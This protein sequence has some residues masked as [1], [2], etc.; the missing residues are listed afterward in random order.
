MGRL[1]SQ[2]NQIETEI[3]LITGNRQD[4]DNAIA[5]KN[6]EITDSVANLQFLKSQVESYDAAL[7]NA[8]NEGNDV[9]TRVQN[10]KQNL[11]ALVKKWERD[12]Q[13]LSEATLNL[14]KARAE[15]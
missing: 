2:F 5:A 10:T 15:K 6:K 7:R 13:L 9:N 12:S 1:K 14:G 3:K 4:Y 11:D 8:Y